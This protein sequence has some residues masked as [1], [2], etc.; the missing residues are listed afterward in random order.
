MSIIVRTVGLTVVVFLILAL[1]SRMSAP[2]VHLDVS[3][4]HV[5]RQFVSKSQQLEQSAAQSNHPVHRLIH[6]TQAVNYLDAAFA[7]GSAKSCEKLTQCKVSELYQSLVTQQENAAL[8]F[9]KV[10]PMAHPVPLQ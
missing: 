6:L 5:L 10:Q 8:Y 9:L 7:M 2:E 3:V 4:Q 1:L